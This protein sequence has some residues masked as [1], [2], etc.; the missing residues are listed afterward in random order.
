MTEGN[1]ILLFRKML[2]WEWY[3]DTVVKTMFL[4]CLLR[5]NYKDGSWK[6]IKYKRGQFITSYASL[7]RETGLTYWQVR[8]SLKAL[9]TTGETAHYSTS[10]YTVI[11]VLNYDSYQKKPQS[12]PHTNR[13]QSA[14]Q[15][16]D[17]P[18]QY[19]KDKENIKKEKKAA[20]PPLLKPGEVDEEGYTQF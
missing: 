1:Y 19:N 18:Q 6:G 9:E 7:A 2:E 15:A 16:A 10:K 8:R 14:T 17:K 11:T 12:K 5:A 20:P 13:T 4:H 3:T